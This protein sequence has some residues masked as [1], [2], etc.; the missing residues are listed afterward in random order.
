MTSNTS[1]SW[2]SNANWLTRNDTSPQT[3]NQDFSYTVAEN[4]STSPRTGTIT[5][6]SS[7]G[8]LTKTLTVNQAGAAALTSISPAS[9]STASAAGSY[10]IAVTSNTNWTVAS[11]QNWA[12]VSPGSGSM[13]GTV[14][15]T[16]A[17]NTATSQRTATIT[18]G[19]ETHK[20]TQA[21]ATGPT[22]PGADAPANDITEEIPARESQSSLRSA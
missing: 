3:G 6:T 12:T 14:T 11:N 10:T 22:G 17:A 7:V 19:G 8:G 16:V 21:A 15:V 9:K 20:L 5:F 13:N 4:A 1:W 2:K 18:I